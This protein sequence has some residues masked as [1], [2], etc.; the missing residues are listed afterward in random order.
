MKQDVSLKKNILFLILNCVHNSL[1]KVT[2]EE[3]K[4]ELKKKED[5]TKKLETELKKKEDHVNVLEI[6][7]EIQLQEIQ[8]KGGFIPNE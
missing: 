6:K 5:Q 1:N 2:K 3:L 7:L 8:K 4:T